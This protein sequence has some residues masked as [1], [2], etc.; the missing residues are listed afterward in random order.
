ME[1]IVKDRTNRLVGLDILKFIAAFMVV[2]IHVI[3]YGRFGED[4]V[5][6]SRCAVPI[7][8]MITGKRYGK[9]KCFIKPGAINDNGHSKESTGGT[10][11]LPKGKRIWQSYERNQRGPG[12]NRS[13]RFE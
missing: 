3:F 1:K 5:A 10:G 11:H 12:K 4:V 13:W 6:I 7:F 8:F 9:E 2:C